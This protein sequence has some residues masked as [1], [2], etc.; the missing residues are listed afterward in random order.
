MRAMFLICLLLINSSV[1][2]Q[3]T[4][5]PIAQLSGSALVAGQNTPVSVMQNGTE[6]AQASAKAGSVFIVDVTAGQLLY[7]MTSMGQAMKS[8][9]FLPDDQTLLGADDSR[10][11][12]WD[13]QTKKIAAYCPP[14]NTNPRADKLIDFALS[15]DGLSLVTLYRS[16][17]QDDTPAMLQGW[18]LPSGELAWSKEL[19]ARGWAAEC[20]LS[21]SAGG[22][23]LAIY[24][25]PMG[26]TKDKVT[27]IRL[28][29]IVQDPAGAMM[30]NESEQA[31]TIKGLDIRCVT[32]HP[33]G[34]E[35]VLAGK[36]PW[37]KRQ[38]RVGPP[39][40]EPN[41]LLLAYRLDSLQEV[42][43]FET[44]LIN[45]MSCLEFN[46]TG[47]LLAGCDIRGL[48]Q[49]AVW[50]TTNWKLV[51][52]AKR[53]YKRW[54]PWPEIKDIR[55]TDLNQLQCAVIINGIACQWVLKLQRP[56]YP[57]DPPLPD[58][59]NFRSHS[60]N[61]TS[62]AFSSDDKLLY[63]FD[64]A[65]LLCTWDTKTFLLKK[66]ESIAYPDK[67][68]IVRR[69]G[70]MPTLNWSILRPTLS[71]DGTWLV[72]N[73]MGLHLL[74]TNLQ[75]GEHRKLPLEIVE[76]PQLNITLHSGFSPDG[77]ILV[78]DWIDQKRFVRAWE[79][80]T[81]KVMWTNTSLMPVSTTPVFSPDSK[82]VIVSGVILE[83]A[84]GELVKPIDGIG[85][86]AQIFYSPD[87]RQLVS[88]D[89]SSVHFFHADSVK[90]LS[91]WKLPQGNRRL[92]LL[93]YPQDPRS[94]LVSFWQN[95]PPDGPSSQV[96]FIELAS[97]QPRLI[98]SVSRQRPLGLYAVSHDGTKMVASDTSFGIYFWNLFPPAVKSGGAL[99]AQE[100]DKHWQTLC[101]LPAQPAWQSMSVLISHPAITIGFMGE[102]LKPRSFER[103][104]SELIDDLNH[105]DFPRREQAEKELLSMGKEIEPYL[106]KA[107]QLNSLEQSRRAKKLLETL[108]EFDL[109]QLRNA[110]AVE[111]LERIGTND[112]KALLA[113]LAKGPED[114]SLTKEARQ[115]LQRLSGLKK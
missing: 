82:R 115:S 8:L 20:K 31:L 47:S 108:P 46:R 49:I 4:I 37:L 72:R 12:L 51:A 36:E 50:E 44:E 77:S 32:F 45:A 34:K 26:A 113:R 40:R 64:E 70:L 5:L 103:R 84:S 6:L 23:R 105:K 9:K 67:V 1:Q 2:A 11:C 75:S 111:V 87:G 52:Q 30:L 107:A 60:Q 74:L 42:R 59:T 76:K 14:L 10:V 22:K 3:Q 29:N 88:Q 102:N 104:A 28:W 109:Q 19:P 71:S 83:T 56:G 43:C 114:D 97:M 7:E 25:K 21:L 16:N 38:P 39:E 96:Q 66:S 61:I 55:F 68:F 13:M 81:G 53:S 91:R 24:P 73:G 98:Y 89:F 33:N 48:D 69:G 54:L 65:S 85:S 15:P 27:T 57:I 92:K 17:A 90:E 58:V 99:T 35:L 79:T 94:I 106:R 41:G 93:N 86:Q 62:L 63:S 100:T 101:E 110:R 18:K 95:V 112:A 80:K 78:A